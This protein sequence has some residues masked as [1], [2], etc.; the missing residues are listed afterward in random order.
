MVGAGHQLRRAVRVGIHGLDRAVGSEMPFAGGDHRA[1]ESVRGGEDRGGVGQA[2]A[3]RDVGGSVAVEISRGD[4]GRR[5]HVRFGDFP[6]LLAGAFVEYR[7]GSR[8]SAS[9]ENLETRFGIDVRLEVG[10]HRERRVV[11]ENR[12][13]VGIQ[14]TGPRQRVDLGEDLSRGVAVQVD[15][16]DVFSVAGGIRRLHGETFAVDDEAAVEL[17]RDN[18]LELR[19]AVQLADGQ[20]TAVDQRHGSLEDAGLEIEH[21]E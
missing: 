10:R 13:P 12:C 9:D 6:E 2:R 7:D 20:A 3:P 15:H 8:G 16:G 21:E 17:R 4:S 19:V 5:V 18:E 14:S 11:P 1:S